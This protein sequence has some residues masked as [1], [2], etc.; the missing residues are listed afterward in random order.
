[1]SGPAVRSSKLNF[2]P[3]FSRSKYVLLPLL[4]LLLLLLLLFFVH[5][6][7]PVE[8]FDKTGATTLSP[9]VGSHI[10]PTAFPALGVDANIKAI[11][12]HHSRPLH[13][14]TLRVLEL[15]CAEIV[16][17]HTTEGGTLDGPTSRITTHKSPESYELTALEFDNLGPSARFLEPCPSICLYIDDDILLPS[18]IFTSVFSHWSP[19]TNILGI[20]G[21]HL[22]AVYSVPRI[23]K[24]IFRWFVLMNGEWRYNTN[25]VYGEGDDIVGLTKFLFVRGVCVEKYKLLEEKMRGW[26]ELNRPEVIRRGDGEDIML[27]LGCGGVKVVQVQGQRQVEDLGRYDG[28]VSGGM[29]TWGWGEEW[30]EGIRRGYWHEEWRGRLW[31]RILEI[32]DQVR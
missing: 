22:S 5:S 19:E 32:V 2:K 16:I 9:P 1:M 23:A 30:Q 13:P 11:I 4:L 14:E 12:L 7:V 21:R 18:S 27:S 26:I 3:S 24:K 6:Y 10:N 8:L 28:G 20:Y 29:R 15:H 31:L 25:N 17:I